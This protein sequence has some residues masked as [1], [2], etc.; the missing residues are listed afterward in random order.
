MVEIL[1]SQMQN[2]SLTFDP[3]TVSF[4]LWGESY[5]GCVPGYGGA[6]ANRLG[7]Q[8]HPNM[9]FEYTVYDSRFLYGAE[10]V[11]KVPING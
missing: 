9:R 7:L 10:V 6:Y 1:R 2:S 5:E 11:A 3:R 8:Q 4:E